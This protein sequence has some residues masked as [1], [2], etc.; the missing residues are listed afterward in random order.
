MAKAIAFA[1]VVIDIPER[2]MTVEGDP[3]LALKKL[4]VKVAFAQGD[5]GQ[6]ALEAVV[7]PVVSTVP[8]AGR[9][10]SRAR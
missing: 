7:I 9:V 5:A 10:F 3:E 2:L 1:A 8:M 6:R 4:A